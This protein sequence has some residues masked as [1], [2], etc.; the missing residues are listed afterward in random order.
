M[1][2]LELRVEHLRCLNS[3][4][5]KPDPRVNVI[6]GANGAGKTT[7]LEAIY[8]LGRGRSFRAPRLG[9]TIQT[10]QERANLFGRVRQSGNVEHRVG[11]AIGRGG[12]EVRVDGTA[13][14]SADLVSALPVQLIDPQIHELIQGGPGE[15]RRFLDW[16]VFHV[17]HEFRVAW[18]RFRRALAQRNAALR[19]GLPAKAVCAWDQDLVDA[20]L[21]VDACRRDYLTAAGPLLAATAK[22]LLDLPASFE[23][24]SGWA[25][26]KALDSALR[27][28]LDRDRAMGSTQSGPHR[29]EVVVLVDEL[30]ARHRLSRG[31][32]KLCAAALV[33]GQ[34]RFVKETMHRDL[35]LLVDEPAAE[36]DADHLRRLL[37]AIQSVDAQVFF[38][39]LDPEA[40]RISGGSRVFH[41]EH[42]E[43]GILV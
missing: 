10:G 8:L 7:V 12:S 20:A 21:V 23:L 36:L 37:Q 19:Q 26:D 35:T 27:D 33:L 24:R 15:R 3:V 43:V 42:G 4:L 41:V 6:A 22:Q 18:P 1:P 17:K 34:G 5:L 11:L 16:G 13:G 31:Q 29:A 30:P 2:V 25:Q 38:T 40:L 9:A 39:A 28:G 14:T 32:Q